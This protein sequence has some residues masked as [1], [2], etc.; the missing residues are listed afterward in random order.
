MS[1]IFLRMHSLLQLLDDNIGHLGGTHC[2]WIVPVWLHIVGDALAFGDHFGHSVLHAVSGLLLSN[3]A[4]HQDAGEHDGHGV[5]LVQAGVLGRAAVGRLEDGHIVADVGPWG[6]SK[7]AHQAG[8]EVGED[9]AVKVGE[10]QHVVQLRLLDELHA[11]VVDDAVLELDIG[12]LLGYFLGRV[13]EEAIGELHDVGLMHGGDLLAPILPGVSKGEP[14]DALCPRHGDWLYAYA[15][16]LGDSGLAQLGDGI[17]QL[18]GLRLA[19]LELDTGVQVFHVLPHDDQVDIF[20]KGANAGV[21][22]AGPQAGVEIEELPEGNV[23]AAETRAHWG[24]DGTLQS[25]L[26]LPDGFQDRVRK[27]SAGL[28]HYVNTSVLNIPLDIESQGIN[29]STG[30]LDDFRAGAVPRN[31]GNSRG[32]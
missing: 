16:I 21:V 32:H 3:V 10:H 22:L 2:G 1:E 5:D 30:S 8:A 13:E 19:L 12:E 7:P 26:V 9:I 11:H 18:K 25:D 20:V 4:E 14:D 17:D 31:K 28:F 27:G 24:G 15:G 23:Y 6:N 29:D